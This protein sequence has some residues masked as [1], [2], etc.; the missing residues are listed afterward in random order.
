MEQAEAQEFLHPL[1]LRGWRVE[2]VS[3]EKDEAGT[4]HLCGQFTLKNASR[5]RKAMADIIKLMEKEKHDISWSVTLKA[6]P[7]L[8]V[9]MQ[10]HS[11]RR[12]PVVLG[13]SDE[14]RANVTL[15]DVRFATLL[16]NMLAEKAYIHDENP[17]PPRSASWDVILAKFTS[18][19]H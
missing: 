17:K 1:F 19:D 15:R 9:K 8:S 18:N 14:T 16:E 12:F 2:N 4:P 5:T 11:A 6:R 3:S 10:T 7:V 13:Q